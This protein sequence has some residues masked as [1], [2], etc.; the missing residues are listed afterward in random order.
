MAPSLPRIHGSMTRDDCGG[1][2]TLAHSRS[3][4][5]CQ[6]AAVSCTGLSWQTSFPL[7]QQQIQLIHVM[8]VFKNT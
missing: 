3:G 8:H 7:Q 6:S 2:F 4:A 5:L 1:T